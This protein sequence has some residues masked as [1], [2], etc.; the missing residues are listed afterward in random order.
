MRK[1]SSKFLCLF[2]SGTAASLIVLLQGSTCLWEH[3]LIPTGHQKYCVYWPLTWT[4][5]ITFQPP[6]RLLPRPWKPHSFTAARG[7]DALYG[8]QVMYFFSPLM[9]FPPVLLPLLVEET[10]GRGEERNRCRSQRGEKARQTAALVSMGISVKRLIVIWRAHGDVAFSNGMR[11]YKCAGMSRRPLT[12]RQ[13][14]SGLSGMAES[15]CP[16][17][18]SEMQ[19]A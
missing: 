13:M 11:M 12:F 16:P 14:L 15:V 10:E 17:T 6:S 19:K 18:W 3:Y 2:L 1:C 4:Q 5:T 7:L 8:S 9:V